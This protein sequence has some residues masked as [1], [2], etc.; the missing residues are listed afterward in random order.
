MRDLCSWLRTIAI[1]SS[2]H[3]IGVAVQNCCFSRSRFVLLSSR[4]C[5]GIYFFAALKCISPY[6]V[7]CHLTPKVTPRAEV[8][9]EHWRWRGNCAFVAVYF[10]ML[11]L[12]Q[13]I[14]IFQRMPASELCIFLPSR[15]CRNF[16]VSIEYFTRFR[17][18]RLLKTLSHIRHVSRLATGD[19][20]CS[21]A[22]FSLDWP[23]G[24]AMSD[25]IRWNLIM[26]LSLCH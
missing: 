15:D 13:S 25:R 23:Y 24:T 20:R 7:P 8:S 3:S 16:V 10:V 4:Y 17:R 1:R 2:L 22:W 18:R 26:K 14:R 5:C 9:I 21:T 6:T 11:F 19:R 12:R